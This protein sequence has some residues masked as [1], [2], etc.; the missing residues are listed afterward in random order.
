[1]ALRL[2]IA[3][4]VL[5]LALVAAAVWAIFLCIRKSW[6]RARSVASKTFWLSA[7]VQGLAWFVIP[8]AVVSHVVRVAPDG[9]TTSKARILGESISEGMNLTAPL[10]RGTPAALVVWGIA[11]WRLRKAKAED[12]PAR[13]DGAAPPRSIASTARAACTPTSRGA[14]LRS[15]STSAASR[16]RR[17][18]SRRVS[19]ARSACAAKLVRRCSDNGRP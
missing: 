5:G 16:S 10:V 12:R 8:V 6:G 4:G 11:V 18:A 9:A 13:S 7:V 2:D 1:M 15:S 19:S 17:A 3:L 14:V